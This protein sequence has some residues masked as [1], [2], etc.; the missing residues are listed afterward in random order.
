MHGVT[1]DTPTWRGNPAHCASFVRH[2]PASSICPVK[3]S[4]CHSA[5]SLCR[6]HRRQRR[7]RLWSSPLLRCRLS[8]VRTMSL[9][10]AEEPPHS[11]A[12][13]A[14]LLGC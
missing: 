13:H 8:R 12:A 2:V 9:L 1:V 3:P 5:V 6:R 10:A 4:T 14:L 11:V 7:A